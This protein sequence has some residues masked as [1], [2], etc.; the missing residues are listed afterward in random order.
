MNYISQFT[1]ILY[2]SMAEWIKDIT[3]VSNSCVQTR[4]KSIFILCIF[5]FFNVYITVLGENS[6]FPSFPRGDIAPTLRLGTSD[7][8]QARGVCKL[9]VA[10]FET[11]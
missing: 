2:A 3:P 8:I 5:Y 6:K 7:S 9:K 1:S 10:E 11:R 4:L